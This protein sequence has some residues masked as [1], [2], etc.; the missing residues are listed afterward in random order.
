MTTSEFP[1]KRQRGLSTQQ[2]GAETLVYD[3]L[4]HKAFCLNPTSS[5]IWSLCDGSRSPAQLAAAAGVE[6]AGP[7]TDD[8]V[9]LAVEEFRR[10]GLLDAQPWLPQSPAVSR[11]AMV[12]T[13]GSTAAILLPAVAT[14]LAPEAAQAY[15]GC[16]DCDSLGRRKRHKSPDT[17][18]T[19]PVLPS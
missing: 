1:R 2:I 9:R 17:G 18:Q 19:K 8:M 5:A 7:V 12:R 14:I 16:A 15:N 13:L 11:R 3:E 4:R 10:N 6:C